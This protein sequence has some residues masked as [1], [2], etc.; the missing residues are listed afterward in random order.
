MSVQCHLVLEEKSLLPSAEWFIRSEGWV[1]ARVAEGAGYWF[2]SNAARELGVGDVLIAP[3]NGNGLLRA[4]R[5]GTLKIQY[6]FVRPR[7]LNGVL[8]MAD[9]QQLDTNSTPSPLEALIVPSR[10]SLARDFAELAS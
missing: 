5:L 2:N 1:V 10:E 4:S 8:L 7:L 6:F 3:G 9:S